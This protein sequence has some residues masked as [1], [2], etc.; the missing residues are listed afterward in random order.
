MENFFVFFCLTFILCF[1]LYMAYQIFIAGPR[2]KIIA[3]RT[4]ERA[5]EDV[6][7]KEKDSERKKEDFKE[8]VDSLLPKLLE[9]EEVVRMAGNFIDKF[10]PLYYIDASFIL[11]VER[12][13][14]HK[15]EIG[16][17]LFLST[18]DMR[19]RGNLEVGNYLDELSLFMNYISEKYNLSDS[20]L[21]LYT[22]Y[23]FVYRVSIKHFSK[24]WANDYQ[25]YFPDI[26]KLNLDEAVNRYCSIDT[27][28]PDD[29][30]TAGIFIYY[31][32]DNGKFYCNNSNYLES[33]DL[34]INMLSGSLDKLLCFE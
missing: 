34:F 8:V 26:E 1:V 27:V 29:L 5:K 12:E 33:Y 15:D 22:T 14:V 7:K 13:I 10:P 32:L 30:L 6:E 19:D 23:L 16:K 17:L 25:E 3:E 11:S 31:L 18:D 24:Q 28:D 9:D 20:I 21:A 2:A 4:A